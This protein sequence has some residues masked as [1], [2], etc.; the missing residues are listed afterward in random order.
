MALRI[1]PRQALGSGFPRAALCE[2]E[3]SRLCTPKTLSLKE[4]V[5]PKS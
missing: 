4:C 2:K 3:L 1:P 5:D